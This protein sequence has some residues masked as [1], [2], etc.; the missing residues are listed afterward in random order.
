MTSQPLEPTQQTWLAAQVSTLGRYALLVPEAPMLLLLLLLHPLT[1]FSPVTAL[2]GFLL[3]L[4]FVVRTTLLAMARQR[5]TNA[6]YASAER[7]LGIV[8]RL[9]PYSADAHT[10][11]GMLDLARGN[12]AEAIS[13]LRQANTLFPAHGHLQSLLSGALLEEGCASEA[14]AAAQHAIELEPHNASA[15]LH[16]ASAEQVLGSPPEVAERHLR[17]GLQQCEDALDEAALRCA[18]AALLMQHRR[19]AE[20]QLALAGMPSLLE[21]CPPAQRA[22]LHFHLGELYRQIGEQEVARGHY[23]ASEAIDPNGRYAAAA[24]RGAR[25]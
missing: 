15:Y 5:I 20:A 7:L 24:W 16:L 13:A 1:G 3:V 17:T 25:S 4:Y 9:H 6:Q 22:G 23:N 10:Q 19:F 8:L 14:F 2:F 21:R 11:Q 18:L 12:S